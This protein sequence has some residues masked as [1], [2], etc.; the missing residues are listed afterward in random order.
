ML[1]FLAADQRRLED[2]ERAVAELLA[3][4]SI[5]A[6]A[7]ELDLS[8]QQAAQARSKRA[9]AD[10]AVAL[11]LADTYHWLLVPIQTDPKGSGTR[12]PVTCTCLAFETSRFSARRLATVRTRRCGR[13]R[14]S[15]PR[16]RGTRGRAGISA[17]PCVGSTPT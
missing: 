5:D 7:T 10:A 15:R 8:A 13:P 17:C 2:L 1:V 11:R 9:D 12:S 3:W 6:E 14:G 4:Q 16:T